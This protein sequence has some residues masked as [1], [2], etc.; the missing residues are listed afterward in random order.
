MQ[1]ANTTKALLLSG[2]S[3]LLSQA[4]SPISNMA[5]DGGVSFTDELWA[6]ISPG[7]IDQIKQHPFI[8]GL[9]DGSLKEDIFRWPTRCTCKPGFVSWKAA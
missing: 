2:N 1:V 5:A 8:T 7:V 3:K 4:H 6:C 9:L